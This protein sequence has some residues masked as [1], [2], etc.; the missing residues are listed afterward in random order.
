MPVAQ[1]PLVRACAECRRL[2]LKCD[3]N[4][5]CSACIRRGCPS[6]CPEGKFILS[7]TKELHEEIETLQARIKELEA[8]L[9]ELQS[10]VT[11]EPHPLLV[12]SLQQ[13]T[14]CLKSDSESSK[15]VGS[16]EDDLIDTFGSL[17]LD[18]AG[19]TVWYGPH[20]GSEFFIPRN[21]TNVNMD[22][23]L[24]LPVDL[25]LLSRQFPF[26]NVLDAEDG[27]RKFVRS[28]LP[29]KE[30]AFESV[31]GL[32]SQ[33]SWA[34]PSVVWD[35]FRQTI[36]DPIYMAGGVANDQQVAVLFITMALAVLA[37]PK[38]PMYHP[39]SHRYYHLSRASMSL[40][41]DVFQSHSLFAIQ[42]L[43]LLATFNGMGNDP[44]GPNRAWGALSLAIRI[45]QMWNKYPEQA[46]RRRRIWW[47]LISFETAFGFALGRPRAIHQT[48]YDTRMPKDSED[49]GILPS[50]SRIRYRWIAECLGGVLDEA[51]AVKPPTYA[52]VIK[53]DKNLRDWDL[54]SISSSND[55][56]KMEEKDGDNFLVF[57]IRILS[58][59]GLREIAL[60]YLHRRYFVEAL[61]RHSDEPLRSKYAMSVLAVHRSAIILLQGIL[62][63]DGLFEHLLGRISFMW[64]H[65]L[66]IVSRMPSLEH[67]RIAYFM[68]RRV[69]WV[70]T[71]GTIST[72]FKLA[73]QAHLAISQHKEGKWPP[74]HPGDEVEVDVMKF[75][76]RAD[77][78]PRKPQEVT[79]PITVNGL[80]E[81]LQPSS[82]HPV[83]FEY[84]KQFEKPL[85]KNG[86]PTSTFP[87]QVS[88][89]DF[90]P[91]QSIFP[92]VIPGL[93]ASVD[94]FRSGNS[95]DDTSTF[96]ARPEPSNFMGWA[97]GNPYAGPSSIS[98][99]L[100]GDPFD[101]SSQPLL[102][103]DL[104]LD[105]GAGN[106]LNS[107]RQSQDQVWDQFLSTLVS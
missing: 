73:E 104:L 68:L 74:T 23:H 57:L 42:Y 43:Q 20:A 6:I 48:H 65:A 22:T 44:N 89:P 38:L 58:T 107:K 81:D 9:A 83:L 90:H 55:A 34:A 30:V 46:E 70:I 50:F 101:S 100:Q 33:L 15:D 96:G 94:M 99:T 35:D 39:D 3:K 76:G 49:E 102:F 26:K 8:A 61:S 37:D 95:F 66:S 51:F 29:I 21:E 12:Q 36:F 82:V 31:G 19:D 62:R 24:G 4:V 78:A 59:K 92:P 80:S 45:A 27:F 14:E 97:S 41:E 16:E 98:N 54:A 18:T 25:L 63:L 28:H 105:P 103:D 1:T 106:D 87:A 5:P 56:L 13:A 79:T 40:G 72:L 86:S 53:L 91:E 75:I 67:K 32:H 93:A 77:F 88:T 60:M 52:T 11:S 47:D 17:T 85:V 7:N 10:K 71:D 2:K 84:M 69:S 64:V